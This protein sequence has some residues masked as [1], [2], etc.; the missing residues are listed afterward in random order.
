MGR[1]SLKEIR[2]KEIIKAFYNVSIKEGLEN[3]SISKVAKEMDINPSLVMHYFNTKEDLIFGLINFILERYKSIYT[4][5]A[6]VVDIQSKLTN[7]INN[8]FSR[9]WNTY[10]DD[11]V[12][13]SCFSLIFRSKNIKAEFMKVH[14]YLRHE[15]MLVI[16]QANDEG[17]IHIDSTPK[18]LADLIYIMVEGS[19]YYLS[20]FEDNQESMDKLKSYRKTAFSLLKLENVN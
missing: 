8:I 6:D 5:E 11:G 20:L 12:F 2:R 17:A 18:E 19:Y 10:I 1:K 15:L 9:K 4:G 3:S 16:K 14:E 13:Y 7:V